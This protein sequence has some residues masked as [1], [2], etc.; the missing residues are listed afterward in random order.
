MRAIGARR[1]QVLGSVLLEAVAVGL[2]ASV[3]G[4]V[5]GVGVAAGLKALLGGMGI[6]FPAGGVVLGASTVVVSIVAGVG[7]SVASAVFPARRAS[8]SP[9]IAAMRD[10]AVDDSAGSRKRTVTGLAV[11]ALGA[12]AMAAGLFGGGGPAR[13]GLGALVVFLGVAV[14][15]PVLARPISRLLG[16]PWPACGACRARSPGRTPCGTP[17]APPPPPRR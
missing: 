14:L 17:S 4:I 8:R 15:G 1:R 11:T 16:A 6:D 13:S 12:A 10:V 9:P 2:V 7:V 5:A 3:A